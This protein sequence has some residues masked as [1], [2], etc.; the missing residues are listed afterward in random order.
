[1]AYFIGGRVFEN[2]RRLSP[3]TGAAG[4]VVDLFSILHEP[5]RR[6]EGSDRGHGPRAATY[7][8]TLRSEID[9]SDQDFELLLEACDCHTRGTTNRADITVQTCLDADRLDIPTVGLSINTRLLHTPTAKNP[10]ILRWASTRA[11]R[12][13]MPEVAISEW[14]MR[15]L[16]AERNPWM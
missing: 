1:M 13:A 5:Q 10:S 7:T 11:A 8:K 15:T 12:R 16:L 14:G 6:S 4:Q 2:G 9:L 3:M